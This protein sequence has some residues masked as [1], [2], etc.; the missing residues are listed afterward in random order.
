MTG[1]K[2]EMDASEAIKLLSNFGILSSEDDK[3]HVL[4][5]AA[6]IRNLPQQPQS[7]VARAEESDISEGYDRDDFLESQEQFEKR[8]SKTKASQWK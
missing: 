1:T 7:L 6:A 4:P 3:L 8:E 2:I 5:L